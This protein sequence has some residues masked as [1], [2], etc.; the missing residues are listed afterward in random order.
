MNGTSL[1]LKRSFVRYTPKIIVR[2][3]P[4][5]PV[6]KNIAAKVL[7]ASDRT[8]CVCR[9]A[10]LNVQIHH[11]DENPANGD[12]ANLAVLC[13]ECHNKTQVQGGFGRTLDAGQLRLYRRDWLTRVECRRAQA[14][15]IAAPNSHS[16]DVTVDAVLVHEVAPSPA[17]VYALILPDILRRAQA[18][19]QLKR[20][21][22]V[23]ADMVEASQLVIDVLLTV[24]ARVAEFYPEGHFGEDGP[25]AHF[26]GLAAGRF[27]WHA[28]HF[29]TDGHGQ[30]GTLTPVVAAHRVVVDLAGCVADMIGSL[31]LGDGGFDFAAWRNQWNLARG[32]A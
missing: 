24:L 18:E 23:T 10:G 17:A 6:P 7:V 1:R 21:T 5:K 22:G 2:K 4:R 15:R 20:A 11:V 12:E 32:G 14:E 28:A 27:R 3:K 8:C 30:T 16:L 9:Q 31:T 25:V 13:F 29:A 26:T 19:T